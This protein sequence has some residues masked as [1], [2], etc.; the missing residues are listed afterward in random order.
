MFQRRNYSPILYVLYTTIIFNYSAQAAM[1][2]TWN[3]GTNGIWTTADNWTLPTRAPGDLGEPVTFPTAG[4]ANRT[5][6]YVLEDDKNLESIFFN[7]DGGD[8]YDITITSLGTTNLTPTLSINSTT[9]GI[10][11]LSLVNQTLNLEATSSTIYPI[12]SIKKAT[13]LAQIGLNNRGA[14]LEVESGDFDYLSVV[15][16]PHNGSNGTLYFKQNQNTT[17]SFSFQITNKAKDDTHYGSIVLEDGSVIENVDIQNQGGEVRL[18]GNST[19]NNTSIKNDSSLDH[20]VTAIGRLLVENNNTLELS[21]DSKITNTATLTPAVKNY[22]SVGNGTINGGQILNEGGYTWVGNGGSVD[23]V[24]ILNSPQEDGIPGYVAIKGGGQVHTVNLVHPILPSDLNMLNGYVFLYDNA[25]FDL[26]NTNLFL[27]LDPNASYDGKTLSLIY[28]PDQV[29]GSAL[30]NQFSGVYFSDSIQTGANLLNDVNYTLTMEQGAPEN[31]V[32]SGD[33][34]PDGFV[35]PAQAVPLLRITFTYLPFSV[36]EDAKKTIRSLAFAHNDLGRQQLYS[37]NNIIGSVM[38]YTGWTSAHRNIA[39]NQ[40][41]F[42]AGK[43]DGFSFQAPSL[44]RDILNTT[45]GMVSLST[46]ENLEKMSPLRT[47][48]TGIWAQPFGQ[49]SNQG[50]RN[51]MHGYT[52]KTSG[53]LIGFDHKPCPHVVVGGAVGSAL[54]T[55]ELKDDQGKAQIKSKIL[56]VFRR[57]MHDQYTVDTSL[58]T[59]HSRIRSSRVVNATTKATNTHE[60]YNVMP[61]VGLRYDGI[62]KENHLELSPYINA[63]LVYSHENGYVEEGAGI[64]NQEVKDRSSSQFRGE[65]GVNLK[66]EYDYDFGK[67]LYEVGVGAVMTDPWKKG[68]INGTANNNGF[69]IELNEKTEAHANLKLSAHW[70]LDKEWFA[71][72]NCGAVIGRNGS[73]QEGGIRVGKKF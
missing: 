58:T 42:L 3:G 53:L 61:S 62:K 64:Y 39:Q 34:L 63:G 40:Q 37:I 47:N 14:T 55:A 28:K 46:R 29:D 36:T 12:L 17:S 44:T 35:L 66:K 54:S 18:T 22:T 4:I 11:N 5:I 9:E 21:E 26:N 38:D 10:K 49:L 6:S 1:M 68:T 43:L 56:T 45:S 31:L 59:N 25:T 16:S 70:N 60:G 13:G 73:S 65:V 50:R 2:S 67:G 33:E 20:G 48:T 57:S 15:N 52:G 8:S 27:V 30:L 32:N 24:Y 69:G 23:S 7:E 41:G 71:S 72:L 19:C 51:N